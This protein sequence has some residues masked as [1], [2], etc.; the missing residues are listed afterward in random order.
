MS[1]NSSL[2]ACRVA[3]SLAILFL[4]CSFSA[5]CLSMVAENVRAIGVTIGRS[6]DEVAIELLVYCIDLLH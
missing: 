5:F 4:S 1:F 6:S 3:L 2:V